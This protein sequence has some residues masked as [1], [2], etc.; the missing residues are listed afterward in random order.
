MRKLLKILLVLA[1]NSGSITS[2][3]RPKRS[4]EL[5]VDLLEALVGD[6]NQE[7]PKVHEGN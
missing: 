7:C 1:L 3:N 4:A 6:K 5:F 2:G